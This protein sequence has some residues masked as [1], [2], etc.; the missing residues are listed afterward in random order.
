VVGQ[1]Y[2]HGSNPPR[3]FIGAIISLRRRG[4]LMLLMLVVIQNLRMTGNNQ[5]LSG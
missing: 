5:N 4:N 3:I 1:S 2:Q